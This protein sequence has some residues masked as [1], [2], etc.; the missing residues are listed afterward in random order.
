MESVQPREAWNKGKLVTRVIDV[1]RPKWAVMDAA[2]GSPAC[3]AMSPGR[4]VW[5]WPIV[6]APEH[7]TVRPVPERLQA[8]PS[9]VAGRRAALRPS[10]RAPGGGWAYGRHGH[11]RTGHLDDGGGI[12]Q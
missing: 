8:L 2:A 6:P 7:I 12:R 9:E 10:C 4:D 11:D 3:S 1:F 5:P